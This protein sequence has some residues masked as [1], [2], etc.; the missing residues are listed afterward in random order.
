MGRGH[1]TRKVGEGV[2]SKVAPVGELNHPRPA[3]GA[4][5]DDLF[6]NIHIPLIE[7][8]HQPQVNGGGK[9][10]KSVELSH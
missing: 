10:I 1:M 8:W 7:N 2:V 3:F 9:D 4:G 6:S 5:R